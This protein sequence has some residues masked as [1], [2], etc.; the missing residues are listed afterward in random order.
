MIAR[1]ATPLL[2]GAAVL[3]GS[4]APRGRD[5]LSAISGLPGPAPRRH[6]DP[7]AENRAC[8]GCH[9]EI[10]REWRG[11]RHQ[12]AY[13]NSAFAA[14]LAKEPLAFCRGCH[15]PE[16]PP[17]AP[18]P[19]DRAELGVGCVTCHVAGDAPLA[20]PHESRSAPHP[21]LRD[22]RFATAAACAGCHEFQFPDAAR[23]RAP[24]P[25]QLTVTEHAASRH[26]RTS[27]AG[28]HMPIATEGHRSHA[29]A[30]SRD[31]LA[32]RRALHVEAARS[33]PTA[34]RIALDVA[35]AGHAFPTGD[36]FRRLA[37]R[38]GALGPD[39]AVIASARRYLA[40]HFAEAPGPLGAHARVAVSD[41]RPGAPAASGAPVIV[42]LDLG[43]AAAGRPIEWEIVYQRVAHVSDGR[44]DEASIESEV[45]LETGTFR[46]EERP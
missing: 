2:L 36:L 46:A 33:S 44:D 12:L 26:A 13:V 34:V 6:A 45:V 31:P 14:A 11:S 4:S 42:E 7:V 5:T 3:L 29:F 40:R 20:A 39:H 19:A 30:S 43:P 17:D 1:R 23:R 28:C 15:A 18:P 38:A 22:A 16:A 9:E 35:T 37:V 8:E 10:A 32:Q 27:C 41:D 21:V 25:M 24:E